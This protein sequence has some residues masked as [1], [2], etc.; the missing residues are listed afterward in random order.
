MRRFLLPVVFFWASAPL[1]SADIDG[2][3]KS[4]IGPKGLPSVV[5]MVATRDE[6]LYQGAHGDASLDSVFR[7]FSMTKPITSVAAMQLVEQGKLDLDAPADR[8]LPE[9][10]QLKILT[11]YDGKHPI[12]KPAT[13]RPTL[14]QLLSHTSGF[15]YGIWDE[16]LA[17]YPDADDPLKAPLVFEPGTKWQYGVSADVVGL[18]VERV[19]G[20]SLEDYFQQHIFR[21]L[22]MTSTTF[23]PGR[24][25]ARI[26]KVANRQPDGTYKEERVPLPKQIRTHGGGGLFSTASDY[27]RFMQMFLRGGEGILKPATIEAM[28]QNQIGALNVR[29]MIS[30]NATF[31][32][33]FGFHIEAGDKFG[34]GFQINAVAYTNGRAANSMAWAG[35]WN[36]FF[37][38]DP[39]SNLC[40]VILMQSSP[41][42]DPPAI[43]TLQA[44]EAAAYRKP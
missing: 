16:N 44:F 35:L 43:Q 37:W 38:I 11:G 41:F 23:F 39:A 32:R 2:V 19:S 34:L 5:A 28:R 36:T 25:E 21:P 33:D 31:T 27:V 24:L 40:A 30:T 22:G 15:G 10:A 1:V 7:I 9:L 13:R 18:I 14:R 29:K 26:V 8:Y 17:R 3:L 4:A 12:L 6:I 42:F 20:Q